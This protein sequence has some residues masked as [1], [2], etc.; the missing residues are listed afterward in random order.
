MTMMKQQQTIQQNKIAEY[1]RLCQNKPFW[2]FDSVKHE[3][4][5][6]ATGGNCCFTHIIPAREPIKYGKRHKFYDYQ[7]QI[8]S[9]LEQYKHLYLLKA[10]GIGA[11][12]L[13]LRYMAY[14]CVS[15]PDKRLNMMKSITLLAKYLGCYDSWQVIRKRY[16]LRWSNGDTTASFRRFFDTSLDFDAMLCKVME[17]MRRLPQDM[18]AVVRHACLTG[19]RPHEAVESV[20]LL[21]SVSPRPTE[22]PRYYNEDTQALEHFRYPEIFIRRTKKAYVSYIT[23][24]QLSEIGVLG[25]KTPTPTY[26]SIRMACYHRSLKMDLRYC[27]KIHASWLHQCSLSPVYIDMLQGRTSKSIL[28]QHYLTPAHEEIK[29]KVLHAVSE[30]SDKLN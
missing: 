7:Q 17:M 24:E 27:R 12:E 9:T 3:A 4:D 14:L 13:L 5:Y 26:L 22:K 18:A 19:L 23:K 30:L 1:S 2:I 8:L 16:N 6:R 11:S 28:A 29:L 20:R 10:G 15:Q 25:C 21:N